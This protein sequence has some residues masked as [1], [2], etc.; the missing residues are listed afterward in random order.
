MVSSSGFSCQCVWSSRW[1]CILQG[2][3]FRAVGCA[4]RVIGCFVR[5][6]CFPHHDAKMPSAANTRAA[7]RA[8]RRYGVALGCGAREERERVCVCVSVETCFMYFISCPRK[9]GPYRVSSCP[10]SPD[11][12]GG[13]FQ[14]QIGAKSALVMQSRWLGYA[15][16]L[17]KES[18]RDAADRPARTR[19][20]RK[21]E[22]PQYSNVACIDKEYRHAFVSGSMERVIIRPLVAVASSGLLRHWTEARRHQLVGS[23]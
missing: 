7:L 4:S 5:I 20:R 16:C 10:V 19:Y 15:Q 8:T 13:R 17:I 22:A 1:R 21:G 11:T 14:R 23:S 12:M 3:W 18:V 9:H 6:V 2:R